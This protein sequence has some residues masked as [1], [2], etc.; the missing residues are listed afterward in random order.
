M[1]RRRG[2]ST[3]SAS[4]GCGRPADLVTATVLVKKAAAETNAETRPPECRGRARDRGR[5]RRILDGKLRD[6]FV[7]DVCPGRRRHV[8]QHER[9]RGDRQ[10]CRRDSRRSARQLCA[11]PPER[12]TSTWDSRPT[13]CSPR[14]LVSRC[15]SAP[16]ASRRP[17]A[18]W[19]RVFST[20][21]RRVREHPQDRAHAP[22]GRGAD[23]ARPGI[24]RLRRLHPA[25]APT[26]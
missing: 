16:E 14:R 10:P 26:I 6:Q 4:A 11:R 20:Q 19:R 8:A 5:R 21:G 9:Q 25:G 12:S 3:I 24:R 17:L 13:T 18:I 22:A 15:C 23:D 7:I 2:P 1:C